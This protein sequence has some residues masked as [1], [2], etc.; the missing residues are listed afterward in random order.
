MNPGQSKQEIDTPALLVDLDKMENNINDMADYLKEVETQLRPH[1]KTH[2]VPEIAQ[3]Q[4][5][6][7]AVGIS[8]QK[9]GEAEVMAAAGVKDIL[10]PNEIVGHS[11]IRRLAGLAR[12]I[13][14]TTAVD[15]LENAKPLADQARQEGVELNV[16]VELDTGDGRSGVTP[17]ERAVS[18]ADEV[19]RLDGLSLNGLMGFEGS[20]YR[21]MNIDERKEIVD[22]VVGTIVSTAE[23]MRKAGLDISV[24]SCGSSPSAKLSAKIPGVTEVRPG[25]YVFHDIMQVE[26]GVVGED[27]CALSVLATVISRPTPNRAVI[28]AGRKAFCNDFGILRHRIVGHNDAEVAKMWEEHGAIEFSNP[29]S[30]LKVGDKVE[31][32][33]YHACTCVNMHDVMIGLRDEVI[34]EV[35]PIA[36]RG[37]MQ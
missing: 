27:R 21:A 30:S 32:I 6:A 18:L 10:I 35:W 8:C 23:Q 9:L 1:T 29:N 31:L 13:R 37:K 33:P 14:I 15:S 22:D 16:L 20:V 11:K 34:R 3:M 19:A 28:D 17:G 36:G 25:N 5:K 12:K 2:K 24:V 4:L 7:G 26:R